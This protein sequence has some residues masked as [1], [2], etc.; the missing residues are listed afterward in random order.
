M[1]RS[2]II[3]VSL[4]TLCP[5]LWGQAVGVAPQP[6]SRPRP[7]S[8]QGMV[9]GI[10]P[11]SEL[12]RRM[13]EPAHE[14]GWYS[15]KML[16]AVREKAGQFDAFHI[17][18]NREKGKIGTIEAVTIPGGFESA[19][20]I[21]SR[22][23]EPE[24]ELI[25]PGGQGLLD[26]ST[27]GVRFTLSADSRTIGAAYFPHGYRRVP[28]GYRKLVDLNSLR[29]GPQSRPPAP[30]DPN[31][32]AGA[33]EIDISPV[34]PAWLKGKYELRDPLKARCAV[35]ARGKLKVAI[36]GADLFGLL[37]SEV[38]PIEA[39]LRKL[40]VSHLMLAMSHNHAAPDTVGIYGFYPKD[41]IGYLQERIATGV[42]KAL[43]KL[44]PVRELLVSSDELSLAGARVGGLFRNA[45]NPGIVDPQLAAV[46]ARGQDGKAIVTIIH[47]ACH[48]EGLEKGPKE[49]S[50]DFPGYLCDEMRK[51]TGA[52]TVFLNGAIGGMVSGDTRE[53]SHEEARKMGL[54][55]AAETSRILDFAVPS[56]SAAFA[57]R[58]SRFEVP[59]TNARFLLFEKLNGDRQV[60]YRGRAISELFHARL[61]DAEFLTIPGELLPELSFELLEKMKGYPRMIVGLCNDELGYIIPA[62]DFRKDAYEESMSVGPAIGPIVRRRGLELLADGNE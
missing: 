30:P 45:R 36:V 43:G 41:Y 44:A 21:R 42:G 15:W 52:P 57:F 56:A 6:G 20:K 17:F 34:E 7:V 48:V 23:G 16:Y 31:L 46:Q 40:G 38:D 39:R 50:A 5:G 60:F 58:R 26:Y 28:P 59:V 2:A 8:Y 12:L 55:L 24:F 25:L 49:I 4:F 3:V 51:R 33:F 47:F 10:T 29:Q 54:R 9:P 35:F 37:K 13:G 61:G 11:V 32:L 19:G 14:G 27:Q 53:R 1:R 22:L 18:G 62:G